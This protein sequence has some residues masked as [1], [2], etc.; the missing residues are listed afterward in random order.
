MNVQLNNLE[1]SRVEFII[2]IDKKEFSD[3]IQMSFKKNVSKYNIPG[4]RKGKI[5]FEIFRKMIG[6]E[7]L[8]NDAANILIER[9]YKNAVEDHKVEVVDYPS[10]DI[11]NCKGGEDF[12]YKATVYVKPNVVLGEYKYLDVEE[13]SYEVNDNDIEQELQNL[14]EK[15]ARLI[16]KDG[17]IEN[18]DIVVIDFKGFIDNEPFDGGEAKDYNLVIG[19]NSFIDNFEDQLIGKSKGDKVDVNVVFPIDYGVDKLKGKEAKFEVNINEIKVK[20][21]EELDDNFAK[22]YS[23]FSTLDEL[24]N[25]IREKKIKDNDTKQKYEFENSVIEKVCS[26]SQVDI[27]EP[28]IQSEIDRLIHDFENKVKYQGTTL[29]QYCQYYGIGLDDIRNNFRDRAVKQVLSNL[30]IEEISKKEN[31]SVNGDEL[32]VKALELAKMYSHDEEKI[33]SIKE[34]LLSS[35]KDS[36]KRDIVM[37][38]TVEFLVN[39][40]KKRGI[41]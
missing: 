26:N 13:V 29:E 33:S 7:A 1:N 23:E 32:D 6:V 4:F 28:M 40:N 8:Y 11:I 12:E 37:S 2:K 31:I 20:E 24:K 25:S 3:A 16:L 14:R 39:Q 41:K 30:V 27:P 10:I 17:T 38:K 19:S 9:T 21:L 15:N 22:T 18:G 35:Y 34:S 36:L 5:P